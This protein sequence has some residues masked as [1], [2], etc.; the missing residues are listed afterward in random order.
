MLQ[1]K[2][3]IIYSENKRKEKDKIYTYSTLDENNK[4]LISTLYFPQ[5]N[6]FFRDGYGSPLYNVQK[7]T[8]KDARE[9][10]KANLDNYK[11]AVENWRNLNG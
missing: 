8:F 5:E 1:I 2:T 7:I 3:G 9:Q 4:A 6:K 10:A 11:L